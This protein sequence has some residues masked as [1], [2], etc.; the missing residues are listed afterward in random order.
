MIAKQVPIYWIISLQF[1]TSW[2]C[3]GAKVENKKTLI[4][5]HF[6]GISNVGGTSYL[7]YQIFTKEKVWFRIRIDKNA[8][9]PLTLGVEQEAKQG[10]V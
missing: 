9:Y 6:D 5:E 7:D 10:E 2:I 3:K 1:D 8:S 4:L